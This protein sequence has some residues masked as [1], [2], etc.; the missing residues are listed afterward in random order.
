MKFTKLIKAEE[1]SQ[2]SLEIFKNAEQKANQ[3]STKYGYKADC[4]NF[5]NNLTEQHPFRQIRIV[6]DRYWPEGWVEFD[7]FH[8]NEV[9]AEIQTTSYGAL[10][11]ED[12]AEYLDH[13][14]KALE[15]LKEL[16]EEFF[17]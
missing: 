2:E 1:V 12:Y 4:W 3:I 13:C 6:A 8:D 5:G 7:V 15:C 16:K 11:L 10:N 9:K 14:H 17:K